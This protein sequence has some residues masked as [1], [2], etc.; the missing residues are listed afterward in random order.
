MSKY[1]FADPQSQCSGFI[2]ALT[3]CPLTVPSPLNTD[4]SSDKSDLSISLPNCFFY[5]VS[6]DIQV[7]L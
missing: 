7:V 1:N 2:N 6:S 4:L 3:Q 5:L